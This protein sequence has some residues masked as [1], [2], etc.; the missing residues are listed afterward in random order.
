MHA[1]VSEKAR[2]NVGSGQI[3]GA[4]LAQSVRNSTTIRFDISA[5]FRGAEKY[6]ASVFVFAWT[7]FVP[8]TIS[9]VHI[10]STTRPVC[11]NGRISLCLF[12]PPLFFAQS[13]GPAR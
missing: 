11:S 5:T 9:L 8:S 13:T 6:F 12:F 10:P 3:Q 7:H 2:A 1:G 4:F